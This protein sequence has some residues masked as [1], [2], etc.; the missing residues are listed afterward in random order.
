MGVKN[1]N[2][3]EG[4]NKRCFSVLKFMIILIKHVLTCSSNFRLDPLHCGR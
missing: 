1:K 3:C 4:M 2:K